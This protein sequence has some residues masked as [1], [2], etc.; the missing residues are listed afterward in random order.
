VK[1]L[2]EDLAA[3]EPVELSQQRAIR[4]ELL[5]PL[6]RRWPKLSRLEIRQLKE[7]YSERLR[8]A[9]H[10]GKRTDE[11]DLPDPGIP[12][13]P[14]I[15]GTKLPEQI[16]P[17]DRPHVERVPDTGPPDVDDEGHMAPPERST[18]KEAVRP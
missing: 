2:P 6:F 18:G 13:D 10:L 7:M 1:E 15:P 9:R 16:P 12:Q 3:M 11:P 4:D 17:H 14:G 5:A 8:I